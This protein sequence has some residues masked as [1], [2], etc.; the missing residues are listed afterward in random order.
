MQYCREY[1]NT[2]RSPVPLVTLKPGPGKTTSAVWLAHVFAEAGSTV[3]LVDA[4][5]SGSAL[6]W[7]DLAAMDPAW[8]GLGRW[9]RV[10]SRVV[11]HP[12]R[13]GQHEGGC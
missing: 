11:P 10:S 5:P 3:L 13:R 4:N 6:E 8:G 9:L 7:S 1:G 2:A 12:V